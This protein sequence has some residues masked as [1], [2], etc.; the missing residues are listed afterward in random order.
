M[1][2]KPESLDGVCG[3]LRGD[4][5]FSETRGLE[6]PFEAGGASSI[7]ASSGGTGW[8]NLRGLVVSSCM[9]IFR[10]VRIELGV[11]G[12]EDDFAGDSD[13]VRSAGTISI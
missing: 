13:L 9:G 10:G 2:D 4:P 8:W 6:G 7:L 5:A 3:T 12:F 11:P 1:L